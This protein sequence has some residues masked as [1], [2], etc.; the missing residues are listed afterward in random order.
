MSSPESKSSGVRRLITWRAIKGLLHDQN[1]TGPASCKHL[2]SATTSC[3]HRAYAS[4]L[5]VRDTSG[6]IQHIQGLAQAS[7]TYKEKQYLFC[8]GLWPSVLLPNTLSRL[9]LPKQMHMCVCVFVCVFVCVLCVCVVCVCARV[10][11]C[12]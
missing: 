9:S 5:C 12:V 2:A 3:G 6:F 8:A 7:V 1:L 11:V 10:C 4:S